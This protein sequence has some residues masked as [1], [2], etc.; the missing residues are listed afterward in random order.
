MN[1]TPGNVITRNRV[2]EQPATEMVIKA[3][4]NMAEKQG[5]K[6]L[7]LTGRHNTRIVP[8]T[9]T[10]GVVDDIDFEEDD[11]YVPQDDIDDDDD[12]M[13]DE[14]E[15]EEIDE[16][17]ADDGNENKENNDTDDV[18]V[19]EPNDVD[20][21]QEVITVDDESRDDRATRT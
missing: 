16:L 3:V 15:R 21:Q 2:W 19:I 5:I 20:E 9:W 4:E 1:L 18:E 8:T 7:K 17:F 12:E 14:I 13:K 11:D 10:P 6:T